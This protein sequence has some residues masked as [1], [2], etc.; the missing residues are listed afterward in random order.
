MENVRFAFALGEKDTFEDVQFCDAIKY[1]IIE[2]DILTKKV[3]VICEEI[4]PTFYVVNLD[5]KAKI[6]INFLLDQEVKLVVAKKFGVT[7]KLDNKYFIPVIVKLEQPDEVLH[8]LQKQM[9]WFLDELYT[10]N[11]ESMIFKIG[12]EIIK[13]KL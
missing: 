7:I 12:H 5:E 3:I 6:L 11:D 10:T 8:L 9:R 2:S 1:R 4:N 13:H